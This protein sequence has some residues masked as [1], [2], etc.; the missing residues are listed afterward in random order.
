VSLSRTESRARRI[1]AMCRAR[2]RQ[3]VWL[4]RASRDGASRSS[5]RS[6]KG[7][8]VPFNGFAECLRDGCMRRRSATTVISEV[9]QVTEGF[10]ARWGGQVKCTTD[11]SSSSI[12]NS[13]T[14]RTMPVCAS[15]GSAPKSRT[16]RTAAR[17]TTVVLY[18]TS[19][20]STAIIGAPCRVTPL[21]N[22]R[23]GTR[24]TRRTSHGR[25]QAHL[26]DMAWR[27]DWQAAEVLSVAMKKYPL[28]AR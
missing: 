2:S 23:R 10:S 28:V 8:A 26:D 1:E 16:D 6:E 12:R 3:G 15:T 11:G 25:D 20:G 4:V 21:H 7:G 18:S 13:T 24:K 27:C 22:G 5:R 9:R 19:W 14:S 17:V